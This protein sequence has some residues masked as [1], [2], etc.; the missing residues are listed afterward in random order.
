[1]STHMKSKEDVK[2][3]IV[4]SSLYKVEKKFED[5]LQ[6]LKNAGADMIFVIKKGDFINFDFL[7]KH[8]DHMQK[9]QSLVEEIKNT[10]SFARL[11]EYYTNVKRL[12]SRHEFPVINE[13]MLVMCQV[14][15]RYGKLHGRRDL[16]KRYCTSQVELANERKAFAI[17]GLNTHY[18]F[19][20]GSWRFWSDADLDFDEMSVRQY[21][22]GTILKQMNLTVEKAPL[23]VTLA[24]GLDSS[25][26]NVKKLIQFFKPWTKQLMNNVSRFVNL[27]QFPL[28]DVSL[29]EIIIE[30]FG[31]FSS[32]VFKDF[33]KTMNTFDVELSVKT[34]CLEDGDDIMEMTKN[35]YTN[36]A[37]ELLEN[38]S[39]F[40]SPVYTDLSEDNKPNIS[41]LVIPLVAKTAGILLKNSKD[42]QPRTVVI[43]KS[44][45]KRFAE[46]K[47]LPNIPK[48][49]NRSENVVISVLRL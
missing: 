26:E 25:E 5:F 8:E 40:I 47:F 45:V 16:N 12:N 33:Q 9:T 22:K 42:R 17:L 29:K 19:Y 21:D 36:L 3:V 1:M 43:K 30:I 18:I 41:D 34:M 4:G 44:L 35:D 32:E 46:E 28:N 48:C 11:N 38:A 14:A 37:E 23:F 7:N 20:E 31:S 49:K 6:K 24:G 10:R 2:D 27:Q 15:K 39:I 13:L